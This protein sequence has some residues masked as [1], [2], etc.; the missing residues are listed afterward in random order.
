M[1]EVSA[2]K[3]LAADFCVPCSLFKA[4]KNVD[5]TNIFHDQNQL[6]FVLYN[7]IDVLFILKNFLYKS[8]DC[9]WLVLFGKQRPE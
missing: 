6:L 2:L 1:F 8:V 3:K 7:E 5:F 9:I 4:M